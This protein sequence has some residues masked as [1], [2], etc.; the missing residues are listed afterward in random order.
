MLH[1][2]I[3]RLYMYIYCDLPYLFGEV[4]HRQQDDGG[5]RGKLQLQQGL[6]Q[7]FN[8]ELASWEHGGQREVAEPVTHLL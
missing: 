5:T 2:N 8:C 6:L 7:I 4:T 3:V 1:I